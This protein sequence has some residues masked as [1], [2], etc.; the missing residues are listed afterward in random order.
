ML[1]DEVE[2][3]RGQDREKYA[4]ILTLLNA[5]FSA[6][7]RVPRCEKVEGE[8][9]VTYFDAFCP[10]ILAGIASVV[11][12]IEDRC[13]KVPMVRKA[14]GENVERFNVRRQ[15]AGLGELRQQLKIWAEARRADIE[16]V[17]DGL[18]EVAGLESFDDRFRDISEPLA[19]IAHIADAELLNGSRRV[20]PELL[21]LFR[22]MAGRRDDTET[23]ATLVTMV[24][25]LEEVLDG[26]RTVFESSADL[27]KRTTEVEGLS[28]IR[29]TKAL[30]SFLG[31]FDLVVGRQSG[32][33]VRGYSITREWLDDI[34][35]RYLISNPVSEASQPSQSHAQSGSEGIL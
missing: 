12:T 18:D 21:E 22:I 31:K 14:P 24:E 15:G 29:S 13:F 16:A 3:M 5:G 27:F 25:L 11:D 26:R 9:V 2:N 17:Y 6:G 34:K 10:K 7:A 33:K 32:G 35:A 23:N 1:L 4:A 30:A 28:W 19:A 8:F 20:W